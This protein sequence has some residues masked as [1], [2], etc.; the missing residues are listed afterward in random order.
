MSRLHG[1]E[2]YVIAMLHGGPG[3]SGE[4][5][6]VS[7]ELSDQFGIIEPLQGA[8]SLHEQVEELKEQLQSVT[9]APVCISGFSWGAWLAILFAAEYPDLVKKLILIGCGALEA[10]YASEVDLE[11][12]RRLSESDK[13]ELELL[14]KQLK[15]CSLEEK[16]RLFARFG[17][18]YSKTDSY[19]VMEID[20]P[21]IDLHPEIFESV[22]PEGAAFRLSGQLLTAVRKVNCPVTIIHGAND[23]HP[24]YRVRQSFESVRKKVKFYELKR[25]GHK[26]WVEKYA[27]EE[28]FKIIRSEL[29]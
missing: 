28:F 10:E 6:P 22:W 7:V 20:N 26:P 11:R 14:R 1:K 5:Y 12:M 9:A 17:K 25:C 24:G 21:K 29:G 8:V 19:H 18:L 16:K 27:R 13:S 4:M 3:A 2:P 23:P 15:T